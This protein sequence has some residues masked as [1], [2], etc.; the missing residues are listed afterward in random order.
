MI[1]SSSAL[2][3]NY[4]VWNVESDILT[5]PI[6][7]HSIRWYGLFW[8]LGIIL[9]YQV[10]LVIFKKE[11]RPAELLDQ[12]SIYILVGTVIGARL[13]HIFFY[14]PAYYLS[15]PFK[16]LAIWEGGLASHG[17]GIGILIGIFLF[18]R[19]HKLSFLWVADRIALVVPIAGACIRL[20]NLMNSEMIGTPTHLPWAFIFTHIDQIPRHPA[21]LYEALYCMLLF[22]LLYS[23]W[24]RPFFRNQTGNSFA[25][26]LILL[27]SFRFFDEYLKI[28]QERFE[29]ALSINMGQILSLPFILDGFI[30]LI[31]NS[32]NKA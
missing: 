25:L 17:G 20:G 12:L 27:F 28:N 4:I 13:G 18:A 15:H 22:V 5:L 14:D 26:L 6:I 21:Q 16:I 29:D 31:A 3:L 1:T 10:L 30:L 8:L 32:R 7:D 11:Y 24:K 19:K 23:L 9:S 2:H